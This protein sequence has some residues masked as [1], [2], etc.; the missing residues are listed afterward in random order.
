MRQSARSEPIEPE[1]ARQLADADAH[2]VV[3]TLDG[4]VMA[5]GVA[6]SDRLRD[7]GLLGV[8]DDLST[9]PGCREVGI[10][11]L[12]MQA[13]VDWCRERACFGVDSLALPGARHTK[14]FFRS[15]EHTSELQSLMRTSYAVFFLKKKN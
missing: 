8:V 10:G 12:V 11:E 2:L 7:G 1:L 6:R 4:T 13:L 15:E 3:G 5:Y 9:E 14:N